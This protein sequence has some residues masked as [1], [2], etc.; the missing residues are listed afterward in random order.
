V[1]IVLNI[2]ER[3]ASMVV[4]SVSDVTTLTRVIQLDQETIEEGMSDTYPS[5]L[6]HLFAMPITDG[7]AAYQRM[8]T[9]MTFNGNP[10]LMISSMARHRF[11]L[12]NSG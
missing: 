6:P 11:L 7:Y 12:S 10:I 1:V 2:G 8:H 4:D 3:V 5:F 9:E